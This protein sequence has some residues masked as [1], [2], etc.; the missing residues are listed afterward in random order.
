M[1]QVSRPDPW[2]STSGKNRDGLRKGGAKEQEVGKGP[3]WP[4]VP[5]S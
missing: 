5:Q 2:L 4:F 1:E 3:L